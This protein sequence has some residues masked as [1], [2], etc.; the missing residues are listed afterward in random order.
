V[1]LDVAV[2][3]AYDESCQRFEGVFPIRN[4]D[5]AVELVERKA[6]WSEV[7]AHLTASA[8]HDFLLH[9]KMD[10]TPIMSLA[11]N[12]GRSTEYLMGNQVI[13]ETM[14]RPCPRQRVAQEYT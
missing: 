6:P 3:Q 1:R 9:W 12:R 2:H 13:A 8:S 14:Y 5:R 4:S 11:G 10:V 7:V